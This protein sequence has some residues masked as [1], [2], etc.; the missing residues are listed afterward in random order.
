MSIYKKTQNNKYRQLFKNTPV[1]DW[2]KI[3]D[4]TSKISSSMI[5]RLAVMFIESK[6]PFLTKTCPYDPTIVDAVNITFDRRIVSMVPVGI[7]RITLTMKYKNGDII[8]DVSS[9]MEML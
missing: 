2:C 9:L 4:G 5:V 3:M 6:F 8:M 1:F 7:Y